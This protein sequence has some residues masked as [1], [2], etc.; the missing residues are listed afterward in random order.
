MRNQAADFI[1]DELDGVFVIHAP[2]DPLLIV[3]LRQQM[4]DGPLNIR[5]RREIFDPFGIHSA[6]LLIRNMKNERMIR[7]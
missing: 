6:K 5:G 4:Q 7:P 3:D 1:G 2:I